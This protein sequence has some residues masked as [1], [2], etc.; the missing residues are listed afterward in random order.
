M[1]KGRQKGKITS[2][3]SGKCRIQAIVKLMQEIPD[4]RTA[5][6]KL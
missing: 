5:H 4:T 2:K 3:K 6:K 1:K